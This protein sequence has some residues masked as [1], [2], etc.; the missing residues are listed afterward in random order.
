MKRLLPI[1][2]QDFAKIREGGYV[3]V[4]KTACIHRLISGPEGVFF[5]SRPRRFGKTLLC[6]TLRAIFDGRRE[7]FEK[8]AERLA[9][10]INSLEWEWKKHPI[11]RLDLNVGNYK[12]GVDILKSALHNA[13]DN[14][15]K[16]YGLE[17]RGQFVAIEFLNLILDMYERFKEKVVVIVDEYDKPLLSTIDE[18]EIHVK[19]REELKGFYSVLKSSDEYLRFVFL[20]GVTKF[21][22]VSIFSDLNH[23]V[24]LT[25]DPGYADICGITQ[26]EIQQNFEPEIASVLEKTGRDRDG[27]LND[28][29]MYYNGYRF[30]KKQLKVY[31]SF[32]LLYHFHQ[33]GDFLPYWYETGTPTFLV[34]LIIKQKINIFDLSNMTVEYGD[35]RKYDIENMEALPVLY[36]SGYLTI[37]DYDAAKNRYTLDYP[38]VEVRSSFAKTL[39]KQYLQVPQDRSS[40]LINK[41]PDALEE[42]NIEAAIEAI[43]QF[44]GAVPYELSDKME[45]YYQTVTYMIFHML[46]I[47][48]QPE[49]RQAAGRVDAIVVTKNFVYCFEFKLD[50]TVEEALTQIDS[51]EYLLSWMG[52]EKKLFKVGVNFNHEKRNIGDWKYEIVEK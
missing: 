49:V 36:Q 31:N 9:L 3:Y 47:N 28:L 38:N 14:I 34:N 40:A 37:S 2:I 50:K 39:L 23:L 12:D 19:M 8:I 51:R 20:T 52:S 6:S 16:S 46:G 33:N 5:L 4:D 42:G 44:M 48:C 22:Q 43:R 41:L 17:L 1:G 27:Y 18:P 26:E 7:L 25:L 10:A 11:I 21:S 30:S 13:L 29:R 45:N 32:G 15:A 24:D 35:F